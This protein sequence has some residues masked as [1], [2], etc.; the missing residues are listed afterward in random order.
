MSARED[1]AFLTGSEIRIA[2]LRALRS[3]DAR[4]SELAAE[5]SCARE[6]A[7]RAVTAFVDRGW[8]EKVSTSDGYRLTRAGEL[9]AKSY[10]EF[11]ECMDIA[12]RFE[13]LLSNL[14]GTA[15]EIECETLAGTMYAQSTAENPHAPI[16]RFLAIV[17]DEPVERF[18]GVTPIVSRVFNEAAARVIG[19]ET[20]AELITDRDVLQTSATEYPESLERAK[21]L[22]GFTLYVSQEPLEFGLLLVDGHAY[23]G[24]YDEHGNLVASADSAEAR[25]VDWVTRAFARV[26]ANATEW[27]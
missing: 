15:E 14:R 6:T 8:A 13:H 20:Q 25:F 9:V 19:P 26:R 23:L 2:V 11:E 16:D 24:A 7:Q 22:D 1:V 17:G 21:D 10:D 18:R 3:D 27:D 12:N 4:P 5:C